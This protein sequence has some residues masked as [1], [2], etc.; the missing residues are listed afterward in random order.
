[1]VFAPL[2]AGFQS[3]LPLTTS[4]LGPSGADSQVGGFVYI[5]G[6]CGSLQ[7][8]LL[9]GWEFLSLLPQPL[10][11]FSL[12]GLRL[13]FPK[14]EPWGC[15]VCFAPTLFLPV[16]LHVNVGPPSPQSA[17]LLG[18][19]A[20][21]LPQVLSTQLCISAPPTSLDEC[22]FF[23]FLAVRLPY[24]S[25]FWQFWLFFVFKFVVVLLLIV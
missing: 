2:S 19:P 24:S 13:Y 18:L 9:R 21:T 15:M 14:L 3:L 11:V 20:T 23:N 7:R 25:I 6:P 8:T 10:Q 17:A 5:L 22:F 16:Y 4:K 12:S 1:M